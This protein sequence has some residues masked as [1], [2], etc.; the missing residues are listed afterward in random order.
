MPLSEE[1]KRLQ[2][3]QSLISREGKIVEPDTLCP[4]CGRPW[5]EGADY[6]HT[7]CCGCF[8]CGYST[9]MIEVKSNFIKQG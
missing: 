4:K 8:V 1:I 2:C 5:K 3:S 9:C 7:I 6:G